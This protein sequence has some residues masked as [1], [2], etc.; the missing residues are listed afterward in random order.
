MRKLVCIVTREAR[1]AK[2]EEVVRQE[3]AAWLMGRGYQREA[4]GVEVT[5]TAGSMKLRSDL[6]VFD[7]PDQ[8][9][10]NAYIVVE[11][12]RADTSPVK[13][14]EAV[15]QLESYLTLAPNAHFGVVYAGADRVLV[16]QKKREE[17]AGVRT[18]WTAVR[19]ARLPRA[20]E[21]APERFTVRGA[22]LVAQANAPPER[23]PQ[24]RPVVEVAQ[25]PRKPALAGL[26]RLAAQLTLA[27][28][29]APGKP[30][31]SVLTKLAAE[32]AARNPHVVEDVHGHV[33]AALKR[34]PRPP[35]VVEVVDAP[36]KPDLSGFAMLAAELSAREPRVVVDD[37]VKI[38][39][40]GTMPRRFRLERDSP[41][42]IRIEAGPRK[43]YDVSVW[44]DDCDPSFQLPHFRATH[45]QGTYRRSD[46][47]RAG[48]WMVAIKNPD[49]RVSVS[50]K[51]I[52]TVDP[53]VRV[54]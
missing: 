20:H 35:P 27:I 26:S 1:S 4:L 51:V 29:K 31:L 50:V 36:R 30:K 18:L 53:E 3:A 40:G 11:C 46:S 12:K 22:S 45:H 17:R 49:E 24:P 6:V 41:V 21:D 43:T 47:L 33:D 25:P 52:V 28:E 7:P 2:P 42:E 44:A 48:N 15:K 32:A 16:L 34:L 5:L 54:R 37:V 14:A 38:P 10:L 9:P 13:F 39:L 19:V 8:D 23:V